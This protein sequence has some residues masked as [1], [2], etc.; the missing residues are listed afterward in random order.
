MRKKK[1]AK[2]KPAP[3]IF[4]PL[5]FAINT[6]CE[7]SPGFRCRLSDAV[8][9]GTC[10]RLSLYRVMKHSSTAAFGRSASVKVFKEFTEIRPVYLNLRVQ[11]GVI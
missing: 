9:I 4:A 11:I 5:C 10:F 8:K 6:I 2:D 3:S 7:F 1:N